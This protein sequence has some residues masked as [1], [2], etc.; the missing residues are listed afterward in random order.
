MSGVLQLQFIYHIVGNIS[1]EQNF[2]SLQENNLVK[3]IPMNISG[4][5]MHVYC[6][7]C[8]GCQIECCCMA[9]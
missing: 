9:F 8:S 2:T 4:M 1:K 7:T 6:N 3:L 5:N